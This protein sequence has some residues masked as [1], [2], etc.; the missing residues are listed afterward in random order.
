MGFIRNRKRNLKD[1]LREY[2]CLV[3][4]NNS[5]RSSNS[6]LHLILI[7]KSCS[8][9][10]TTPHLS[11]TSP[12][13]LSFKNR[14]N[15]QPQ[16]CILVPHTHRIIICSLFLSNRVSYFYVE[17]SIIILIMLAIKLS[18]TIPKV[19]ISPLLTLLKKFPTKNGKLVII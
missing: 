1:Q 3:S 19:T 12:R 9:E 13:M 6:K 17:E 10:P 7:F 2:T 14:K 5:G 15:L 11:N 16:V 4:R 18:T 8:L